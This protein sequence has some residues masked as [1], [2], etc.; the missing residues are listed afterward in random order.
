MAPARNMAVIC[1]GG[2][3]LIGSL[4]SLLYKYLLR[5]YYGPGT[6]DAKSAQNSEFPR[7][8]FLQQ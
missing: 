6:V 4:I 2:N 1:S 8:Y 7:I 3:A 5:P